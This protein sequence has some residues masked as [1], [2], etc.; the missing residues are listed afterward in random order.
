[1]M[2]QP[3]QI[4]QV[5]WQQAEPELKMI[6]IE[7]F[8]KEQNVPE[9]L[10]W[11][12][13]DLICKHLL[14]FSGKHAIATARILDSGQI[15]RMAVLKEYRKQGIG[16][17]MLNRLLEMANQMNLETVFLNAQLEAIP[18]YKSFGFIEQGDLFNDAGIMHKRMTKN[19]YE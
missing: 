11:D 5:L 19:L 18:F 1:M 14:V 17:A 9:E 6:R 13:A 16:S 12:E 4:K 3:F 7:V 15:G 10:E 2:N 8:I